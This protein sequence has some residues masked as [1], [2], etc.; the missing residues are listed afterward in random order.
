MIGSAFA[1]AQHA[2][3]MDGGTVPAVRKLRVD[4]RLRVHKQHHAARV[5]EHLG[6]LLGFSG[7][8]QVRH[9]LRS[10]LKTRRRGRRDLRHQVRARPHYSL[11]SSA[12]NAPLTAGASAPTVPYMERRTIT[13]TN[14]PGLRSSRAACRQR[15]RY[16]R[17]VRKTFT[18][19]LCFLSSIVGMRLKQAVAWRSSVMGGMR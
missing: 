3:A 19:S 1:G 5:V 10:R 2:V 8:L 7:G 15:S 17:S 9:P 4:V 6:G 18:A 12:P 14:S 13:R 16:S 11:P